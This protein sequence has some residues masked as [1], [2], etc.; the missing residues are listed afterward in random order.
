[1]TADSGKAGMFIVYNNGGRIAGRRHILCG[2][3]RWT[4]ISQIYRVV[5]SYLTFVSFI[6]VF[7]QVREIVTSSVVFPVRTFYIEQMFVSVRMQF[8]NYGD[9][10]HTTSETFRQGYA[11][12]IRYQIWNVVCAQ[13]WDFTAQM[14]WWFCAVAHLRGN[15]RGHQ[16]VCAMW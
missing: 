10:R 6:N 3:S 16:G 9:C 1:V 4:V 13:E 7:T 2:S 14:L 8:H 15:T 5:A 11:M 12:Y